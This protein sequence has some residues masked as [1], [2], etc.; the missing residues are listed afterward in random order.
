[1]FYILNKP[2]S[3][4]FTVSSFNSVSKC[5][6]IISAVDGDTKW[7]NLLHARCFLSHKKYSYNNIE[8]V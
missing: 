3:I 4:T 2:I 6:K 7:L 5:Y 8:Q 1:M